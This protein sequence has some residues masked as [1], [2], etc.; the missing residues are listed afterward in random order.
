MQCF[1]VHISYF[2]LSSLTKCTTDHVSST[3]YI[4][5][6]LNVRG[7]ILKSLSTNLFIEKVSQSGKSLWM[8]FS[9]FK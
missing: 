7:I 8:F 5:F 9:L 1:N 3:R 4:F 6:S 2:L